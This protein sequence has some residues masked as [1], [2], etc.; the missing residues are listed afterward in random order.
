[1]PHTQPHPKA[2]TCFQINLAG[3]IQAAYDRSLHS[4]LI[5]LTD[6]A[7]RI[8]QEHTLTKKQIEAVISFYAHRCLPDLEPGAAVP[9]SMLELDGVVYRT[10]L[11]PDGVDIV[12]LRETE[13]IED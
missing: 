9:L 5:R 6:W 1:M 8:D 13:L 10:L 11:E 12:V 2:G 3:D 7:D 4:K